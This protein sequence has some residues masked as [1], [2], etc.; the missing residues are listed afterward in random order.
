MGRDAAL[1]AM[2]QA[3]K[4]LQAKMAKLRRDLLKERLES[5]PMK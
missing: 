1:E 2:I 3:E 5:A 4:W